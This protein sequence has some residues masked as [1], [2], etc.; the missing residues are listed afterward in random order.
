[1]PHFQHVAAEQGLAF[2]LEVGLF[3]AA[4]VGLGADAVK[5]FSSHQDQR[6]EPVF[7]LAQSG[8][9]RP[10]VANGLQQPAHLRQTKSTRF[11]AASMASRTTE[12]A[13]GRSPPAMANWNVSGSKP[14][15]TSLLI[16]VNAGTLRS[17]CQRAVTARESSASSEMIRM[18]G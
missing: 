9:S 1:M 12:S 17:A 3:E 2:E 5:D 15:Q 14:R 16:R 7:L 4:G 18:E 13:S 8:D 11:P 10:A 6:V